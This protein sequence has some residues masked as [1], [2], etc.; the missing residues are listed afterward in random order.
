ME[1]LEKKLKRCSTVE[2]KKKLEKLSGVEL[3]IVRNIITAREGDVQ[4]KE[5]NAPLET[6]I[7]VDF[8][9]ARNSKK[10]KPG[11]TLSGLV[12][13]EKFSEKGKKFLLIKT[14]IGKFLKE[15]SKC[16]YL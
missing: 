6:S 8:E 3:E 1:T 12:V 16:K 7:F 15:E 11:T 9:V 10:A 5:T 13:G 4:K 2:L 14:Q